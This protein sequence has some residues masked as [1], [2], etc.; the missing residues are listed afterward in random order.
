MITAPDI[1]RL[2]QR[3]TQGRPIVSVF[4]NLSV[5]SENKRTHGIFL[6]RQRTHFEHPAL[7]TNGKRRTLE[8][9]LDR[10]ERWIANE[11]EESNRGAALYLEL[12]GDLIAALQLPEPVENRIT[13]DD[14]PAVMP[15]VEV[16]E[17]ESPHVVAMV[18]R[19]H[20]RLLAVAFG[21]V[22][23]EVSLDPEPLPVAHDVQAGGY[24]QKNYQQRKAEEAKHFLKDF[25]EEL[26][27]FVERHEP[28]GL[29]LLGTDENV[30]HFTD[31]LPPQLAEQVVQTGHVPGGGANPEVLD[32]L[33]DFFEQSARDR[34][35][36]ALRELSGRVE[37]NHYAV[38]G[39]QPTL[40]QLR[41]GNV[42][43]LVVQKGL[44]RTGAQCTQC[45]VH[46]DRKAE[47]C[48]YCGGATRGGI[49][50]VETM[51]RQA[52]AQDA[53]ILFTAA[54]DVGHYEGVGALLRF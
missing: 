34:V 2:L 47:S 16:M 20:L 23:D 42:E 36:E 9:T 54:G 44:E 7:E 48:P 17:R 35:A 18:D 41:Q 33:S 11:F 29:V 52:A 53:R 4:L 40:D 25:A 14:V 26:G 30:A 8:A 31:R 45:G 15:L 50:L 19:E 37:Q 46:L 6:S 22:L 10:V 24:S 32:R 3:E 21:R 13:I 1:Q 38:S 39:V 12:G 27:R 43:T 49:D 51:V 28:R 5:N